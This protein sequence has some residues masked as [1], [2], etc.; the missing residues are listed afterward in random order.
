MLPF[1]L[2]LFPQI[3]SEVWEPVSVLSTLPSPRSGHS[4]TTYNDSLYL[5]G[6]CDFESTCYNDVQKYSLS[7]NLWSSV[8]TK[9]SPPSSREGHLSI[10]IGHFIYIHGGSSQTTLYSDIF[11]FNL[12]TSEW[13]EVILSGTSQPRAYHSG[14]LHEHGLILIFGGYT[15]EGTS[16]ET[17]IIDTINKHWGYPAVVG[18]QPSPRKLHSLS[19]VAEKVWM[20]GGETTDSVLDEMWYFD[21]KQRH[22]FQWQGSRPSSRHGHKTLAH[23]ENIYLFGGCNNVLRKCFRDTFVFD[24]KKE[25]WTLLDQSESIK[26]REAF[27]FDFVGGKIFLFG[28]R[29]LMEKE[30]GDFWDFDSDQNCP[31]QC[32]GSGTCGEFGCSC[33]KG[34]TGADCS[35]KAACRLD[36]NDH[37]LCDDYECVCY[38][39]YY[40]TYCQGLVGCPNNCT[41][42]SHGTCQDSSECECKSGYTGE[43]CSSREDWKLCEDLCIHG[44][45]SNLNCICS[46]GWVGTYCDVKEPVVYYSSSSTS[47]TSSTKVSASASD[48]SDSQLYENSTIKADPQTYEEAAKTQDDAAKSFKK[49]TSLHYLVPEMF[50]FVDAADP[51]LF[52][53]KNLRRIPEEHVKEEWIENFEDSVD[54][55]E[56]EVK[57]C[58]KFCSHHGTCYSNECYCEDGYTGDF[59]EIKEEDIYKGVELSTAFMIIFSFLVIGCCFGGYY[60]NKIMKDIKM[61]EES[62]VKPPEDEGSS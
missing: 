54:D 36:C 39:G 60:L 19:K 31:N 24:T 12:H 43:D 52:Y 18:V 48:D 16:G 32:S 6:G 38:P 2:F 11:K 15:S 30:Y 53:A 40:G 9:N 5:F 25:I 20:F 51:T 35:S 22:W 29:F 55:R 61:R 23:G 44:K 33:K 28:G 47:D 41:S 17:L 10:L 46:Q 50:G 8:P 34:F 59:C 37:G 14:V 56:D 27:G 21:L 57:G 62:R 26:P 58:E 4:I 1:F 3:K 45:C 7:T 49:E 42:S 13:S